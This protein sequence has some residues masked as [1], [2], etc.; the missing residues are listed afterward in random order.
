MK[1]FS[2]KLVCRAIWRFSFVALV[3]SALLVFTVPWQRLKVPVL[4]LCLDHGTGY[5]RGLAAMHL[6]RID[7]GDSK[8]LVAALLPHLKDKDVYVREMTAI[9]LGHIR[10]YPEQVVPAL[11]TALNKANSRYDMSGF[12]IVV[13]LS[14]YGTNARPWSPIFLQMIQSN[15]FN[16]G[17][18]NPLFVLRTIDPEVGGLLVDQYLAGVSNRLRQAELENAEKTTPQN[19]GGDQSVFGKTIIAKVM[20]QLIHVTA[21][22][23]NALLV[24]ILPHVSDCA[25]QLNLPLSQPITASQVGQFNIAPLQ[26]EVGGGLWLT[27]NY[28]FGFQNGYVA[29]FRSPDDFFTMA[30]EYWDHLDRYV[31]KDNITTNEAIQLARDAFCKLG[32]KPE[33]FGINGPPTETM[34]PDDDKKWGHIPCFRA[35]WESPKSRSQGEF[36]RSYHVWF[37]I[38][39]QR[40]QVVA[41]SLISRQFSRP[42]PKI[43]VVPELESDYR[44]RTQLHMHVRTNAPARFSQDKSPSFAASNHLDS[45]QTNSV[46]LTN[47]PPASPPTG[48]SETEQE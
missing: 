36:E 46:S 38:D 45:L 39:M 43:D 30:D 18:A 22:Y 25:K 23:S 27:N 29:G 14:R 10:Q 24:A 7:D 8:V 4:I 48:A 19:S 40:N 28:W 32:Y 34:G 41:M 15:S 11:L 9:S 44:K 35:K 47:A 42:D 1:P 13:A 16:C 26:G 21:T 20:M 12:N 5:M 6:G 17:L 31:G 37:D 3:V 2:S 33:D